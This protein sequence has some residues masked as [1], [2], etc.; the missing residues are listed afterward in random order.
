MRALLKV[1]QLMFESGGG[2]WRGAP[3]DRLEGASCS[4]CARR[5]SYFCCNSIV[6]VML[7]EYKLVGSVRAFRVR[8]EENAISPG[9]KRLGQT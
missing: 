2:K 9:S 8:I 3:R 5:G 4:I 1:S 6:E 7:E